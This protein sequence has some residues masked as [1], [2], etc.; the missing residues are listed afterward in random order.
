MVDDK[1]VRGKYSVILSGWVLTC[2]SA[3]SWT[4]LY[5]VHEYALYGAPLDTKLLVPWPDIPLSHIILIVR[6]PVIAWIVLIINLVSHWI[7]SI[8]D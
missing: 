3:Y 7:N 8:R 1:K 6:K 2:D 4:P 5:G